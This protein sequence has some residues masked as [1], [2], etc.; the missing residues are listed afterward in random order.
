MVSNICWTLAAADCS[1][2]V[3]VGRA[4]V[5]TS[6]SGGGC[7]MTVLRPIDASRRYRLRGRAVRSQNQRYASS[8]Y[9]RSFVHEAKHRF[10]RGVQFLVGHIAEDF[11][12][13]DACR[14]N[15]GADAAAVLF[16]AGSEG[17]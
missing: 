8:D 4:P 9:I 16:V 17:H 5:E 13:S 3:P 6:C 15:E 7:V 14:D 10:R 2:V 12:G 1:V 11:A